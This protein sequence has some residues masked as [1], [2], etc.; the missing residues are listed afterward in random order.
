MHASAIRMRSGHEEVSYNTGRR[1]EAHQAEQRFEHEFVHG[2]RPDRFCIQHLGF[3]LAMLIHLISREAENGINGS[4]QI[5]RYI[6]DML[7]APK[8]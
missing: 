3:H 7:D 1:C 2:E 8:L 5:D 4:S 6:V